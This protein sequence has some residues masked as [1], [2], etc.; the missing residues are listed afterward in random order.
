MTRLPAATHWS[1]GYRLI[2]LATIF[3]LA[4]GSVVA[5]VIVGVFLGRM[6]ID[7][8]IPDNESVYSIRTSITPI[9]APKIDTA[10]APAVI[11][12]LL[13][14]KYGSER[15]SLTYLEKV[16][17]T[18][19][20]DSEF[21]RRRR[22]DV[23]FVDQNFMDVFKLELLSS[24]G[25]SVIRPGELWASE[26]LVIG[27]LGEESR[28]RMLAMLPIPN[29]SLATGGTYT[30]TGIFEDRDLDASVPFDAIVL[31]GEEKTAVSSADPNSWFSLTGYV[32]FRVMDDFELASNEI[33]DL[34]NDVPIALPERAYLSD[35][36]RVSVLS[37]RELRVAE[38]VKGE[39]RE[40]QHSL[41]TVSL[42]ALLA[43][44]LAI[45]F[46]IGTALWNAL[47]VR[48]A[49][50]TKIRFCFGGT[51]SDALAEEFWTTAFTV[52]SSI[53]VPLVA[54]ANFFSLEAAEIST[55]GMLIP[56]SHWWFL[57]YVFLYGATLWLSLFLVGLGMRQK[58]QDF[59]PSSTLASGSMAGRK[60]GLA[61]AI[62]IAFVLVVHTASLQEDLSD[63]RGRDPG[64]STDSIYVVPGIMSSNQISGEQASALV[65]Q[66]RTVTGGAVD[67]ALSSAIPTQGVHSSAPAAISG[68]LGEIQVQVI[69]CTENLV[70]LLDIRILS[71]LPSMRSANR[72]ISDSSRYVAVN[73]ALAYGLGLDDSSELLGEII[74]IPSPDTDIEYV[75]AR[76][77]SN[78]RWSG[79]DVDP[80][81]TAYVHTPA[82]FDAIL[83]N[84]PN[85]QSYEKTR[86]FFLAKDMHVAIF[87]LE[88]MRIVQVAGM[89]W[90]LRILFVSVIMILAIIA[91]GTV[92]I[93]NAYVRRRS[94]E[95]GLRLAAGSSPS[96]VSARFLAHI[97]GLLLTGLFFG[98][99]V[100]YFLL[101][102]A[103]G[104]QLPA[105]SLVPS[106]AWI[107]VFVIASALPMTLKL[108][109][110]SVMDLL[111]QMD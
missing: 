37:L 48:R 16:T 109:K 72:E 46:S 61:I 82:D 10:S 6:S 73:E 13:H 80:L 30:I 56:W 33:Q 11:I 81:P 4:L 7:G 63:F 1:K 77:V 105:E 106:S 65:G 25:D 59:S 51:R 26:S 50:E 27:L 8:Q 2:L 67:A 83:L 111:G 45:T 3:T 100:S 39:L 54:Y 20:L 53:A 89:I 85:P 9:R 79:H 15:I 76:V 62:A 64:Y 97:F 104:L 98:Y 40:P 18:L 68:H 74:R 91:I 12:P 24:I 88:E 43:I 31:H 92:T 36:L 102:P 29:L 14:S 78:A 44:T 110:A 69:S 34:L 94:R 84:I 42:V 95:L 32:F 66:I 60:T 19:T 22:S 101:A 41:V 86:D 96:A 21:P 87:P 55:K 28:E 70:N 107:A 99:L 93:A 17:Q 103:F 38:S 49:V 52:V 58:S 90:T 5:F 75:I 23:L 35:F 108:R 71:E 57:A 47:H